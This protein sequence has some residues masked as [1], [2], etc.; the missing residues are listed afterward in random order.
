MGRVALQL[1]YSGA[2]VGF[3]DVILTE[4]RKDFRLAFFAGRA[5]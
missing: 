4:R 2:H 1:D 3:L 5:L